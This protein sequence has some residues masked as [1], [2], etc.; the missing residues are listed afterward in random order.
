MLENFIFSV[1][2]ALPIFFVMCIGHVLKRK[3]IINENFTK[4]TNRMIFNVAL[5]IKLFYDVLNTSFDRSFDAKLLTFVVVGVIVSALIAWIIGY[6]L[7]KKRSQ[8]GAF[9]QGA[10]RGNFLYVGLS[11]LENMTGTITP[12]API[13]IAFV[14]PLYNI[15][16][17]LILT[18]SK[19]EKISKESLKEMFLNIIKNPFIIAI[20][21]GLVLGQIGVTLPLFLAR[22]M[23]Y[24]RQLVTP[25]ALITIGAT[26]SFRK[27][28]TSLWPAIY[29]SIT[30]L[31][32]L[33]FIAVITA[34]NFGFA[35]EDILLL[36]VL[37][38]VPTSTVSYVMAVSLDGDG[39]LAANII[40]MTTLLS[41][42]SMTLFVFTFKTIG[43]I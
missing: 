7:L 43:M 24:F 20:F 22:T 23:E 15:I 14:M 10:F 13:V 4:V 29:A 17:V 16:S 30:K 3:D 6:I 12:K 1:G 38:G 21:L 8:L 2:I 35:T 32:V 39:D 41:I 40:M 31:V 42:V 33:P 37:F 27:A 18:F 28:T 5:P 34:Y 19:G 26:F 9:T 36:Y 25:L 11:L